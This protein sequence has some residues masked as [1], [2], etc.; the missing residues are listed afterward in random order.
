MLTHED[1]RGLEPSAQDERLNAWA[2]QER[3]E[4]FDLER[5]PLLRARLFARSD[6]RHVLFYSLHHIAFDGW[7]A[8]LFNFELFSLYLDEN[9]EL[10]STLPPVARYA[11]F[12]QSQHEIPAAQVDSTL[13]FWQQRLEHLPALNLP[14]AHSRPPVQS[15]RGAVGRYRL[16]A[17][18][19]R[20]IGALS[21]EHGVTPFITLLTAMQVALGRIADQDRFVMG[22]VVSGRD[23]PAAERMIGFFI[24]N[25]LLRG[26]LAD[27]LPFTQQ[28]GRVRDEFLGAQERQHYP[29]QQLVQNM[30]AGADLSRNP[31]YQVSFTYQPAGLAQGRFGH[32]SVTGRAIVPDTTHMDLE[33]IAIP[34]G[35]DL[36][37]VW[38][39]A[40]DL[41]DAAS[42]ERWHH[43]FEHIVSAAVEAPDT[44][45]N[46]L[47]L[48]GEA[49]A[50]AW[51]WVDGG[52]ALDGTDPWPVLQ[53]HA[54][55]RPEHEV[56]RYDMGRAYTWAQ[57]MARAEHLA[58][59]IAAH[60]EPAAPIAIR[61]H[62]G[63]DYVAAILAAL[64]LG[65]AWAPADPR[66]PAQAVADML[67]RIGAGGLVSEQ[68]L[69]EAALAPDLALLLVDQP[70]SVESAP[71]LAYQAAPDEA[72]ALIQHTSGSEGQ[73]KGVEIT[74]GSLRRR[75]A[76]GQLTA[77]L[78]LGD[79]GCLKT[80]PAFVDAVGELLD[81]L[82]ADMTLIVPSPDQ[83]RSPSELI[84]L[85][86][87]HGVTRLILTPSLA[88]ALFALPQ[89]E[90]LPLRVLV[91]GGENVRTGLAQRCLDALPENAI[92]LNY[93]GSTELT[94]DGA[95]HQITQADLS[96]G[97]S[98][99]PIGR[100]LPGTT[101]WLLD[102]KGRLAAPGCAG[103][104]HVSGQNLARG[105]R[106][107]PDLSAKTFRTWRT[108]GGLG[109][110]LYAT[111]DIAVRDAQG[112]LRCLGRRDHQLK[113]R[114]MRV[115]AGEVESHLR[116]HP[117]VRDAIIALWEHGGQ[118]RLIGHVLLES[119]IG[120][121]A[122]TLRRHL[123]DKLPQG[124]I[125][126]HWSLQR[127]WPVTAT[128]KVDRRRLRLDD[129]AVAGSDSSFAAATT[130]LQQTIAQVWQDLLGVQNVGI[131]DNFFE[132]GG[133]SL[134]LTQLQRQLCHALQ[135]EFPLTLLFQHP[136]IHA[137]AAH[138]DDKVHPRTAAAPLAGNRA[139]ARL[140][141][142]GG[143]Q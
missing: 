51:A 53:A 23:H 121:D 92:L 83:A 25:L 84:Q 117:A 40:S 8:D 63:L 12:A 11:D 129:L 98:H 108:P 89:A 73:P 2:E 78:Q 7:S 1:L 57:L 139:A 75:L 35:N 64:R 94:S 45:V 116:Q 77:P 13:A 85:I 123:A 46:E 87:R 133:N 97:A 74:Y 65:R 99:V 113:L 50:R 3:Q 28:L 134:L 48:A 68:A 125:P 36:V 90:G 67:A 6:T 137:L 122:L 88:D 58:G 70:A 119:Q 95:W 22:S 112:R 20:K 96:S 44:R 38:L 102:R 141:A 71:L 143:R 135:R 24:N 39:Y 66:R 55:R 9:A 76:W 111:G 106:N 31:L 10:P 26:D 33:I 127:E 34:D 21:A 29:L 120:V 19:T 104:I 103:E 132:M 15:F 27:N 110:R 91:L 131:H 128:G 105:Y 37:L 101:L 142:R 32:L 81:S 79:I 52:P 54:Q 140:A 86:Y 49:R 60:A 47:P 107:A 138:L 72:V 18:L 4:G 14:E 30:A 115:E 41:Y 136:N 80:S 130:P 93:Y 118:Q 109:T 42:I 62:P 126:S 43:A 114:G 59:W 56:L 100:P 5:G 61:L 82:L 16:G 17:A 69:W 124:L